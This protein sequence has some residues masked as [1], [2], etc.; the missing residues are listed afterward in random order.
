MKKYQPSLIENKWQKV[1]DENKTYETDL[2]DSKNKYYTLVELPYSSGDLHIGHWFTFSYGDVLSRFKRMTGLNVVYPIGFD[3]FGLPAENA[4]IKRGTHPQDWAYSNIKTMTDQF[5]KMGNMFD[6]RYSTIACDPEFYKWNQWIFIK[7]FE[8]GIAYKGKTLSNWCEFDQTVLAE[9]NI[10]AGKCWRCGN[11]V[12]KKEI[13]QWFLK[14]TAYAEKLIWPENPTVDYPKALRD[15]Q[16]SWI[17]KSEGVILKFDDIEV[18]TTRID[19]IFGATF[20]VLSPE[21]PKVKDLTINNYEKEVKDYIKSASK[22]S[23]QERKENKDKSGVFTGSYVTNPLS[24]EKIPVWVADYVLM[25]YG[26]GAIMAVPAHDER[27][28]EFAKKH[29]LKIKEVIKSESK[30]PYPGKGELINSEEYNG[31]DYT[32][33]QQKLSKYIEKNHLGRKETYY[34][35]RD[36]S[37]SRQ[38]YWG[39][40]IPIIYCDK[41]GMVPVPFEDLPVKLPYEVDYSPKGK[42]PLATAEEWVKVKCPKCSGD[43]RRE[44]ETM[45]GFMDNSW[46]FFRY[47]DPHNDLEI[48]N[49]DIINDWL[50]V[51]IYIGGSEHTYGHALYSRFFTKFFKDIGLINFD[52]YAQKRVHHGV[53]LGPDGHR[54]SKSRGNIINPDEQVALFGAD[55][56]RLYLSF[57]GPIDI[58][59]SWNPNGINGIYHFLQRV[60]GLSDKVTEAKMEPKDLKM[61]HKT[62]KKLTM[63]M[64]EIKNNT[65]IA[66]LMEWLNFLS[67]KEKVSKEEYKTLLI[68][69]AP[70]A[71]HITEELW[72]MIGEKYSIHEKSWPQIDEKYLEEEEINYVIQINGKVRDQITTA[73]DITE[74][75]LKKLALGSKKVQKFL[76]EKEIKKAIFVPGKLLNLVI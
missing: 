58:V 44:T 37:I 64:P 36:W 45:D 57:L 10:E 9:E 13:E 38:R 59:T 46:Y 40:P 39:T 73:K 24:R 8:K 32:V 19:T 47:L 12:V 51:D 53:I 5:K 1:W 7:M 65:S 6:W 70:F 18:F 69:L 17:G 61:M 34:H 35:L 71:P 67:K 25:G 33:A 21:H 48:F 50:P 28:F 4:A 3:A 11:E 20:L 27:D 66:S 30:L 49:Q 60:W 72:E 31:I 22:K 56:I 76:S 15:A 63:D 43:A 29:S 16:N 14:I 42:A 52:E 26:T 54:M 74:E 23:E 68:L 41:D 75:D 2:S 55:T 62:I